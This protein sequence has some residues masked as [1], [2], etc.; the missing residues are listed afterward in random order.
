MPQG[1]IVLVDKTDGWTS[2]DVVAKSRR[3]LGTRKVGHAGTLD[4][5][6][7]GLLLLGAGPATRLLT[8]LVGL[9]K[10][11]VATIRL[12]ASTVTD[13][14]EGEITETAQV[15]DVARVFAS[16]DLIASGVA[17][18]TGAIEQSPSA[19]SA[20]K[21][22]G[23]RA[24][25]RVRAGEQVELKKRP[26]TIHSFEISNVR[27][28][29][30]GQVIDIDAVIRCSSGTY[31]RALARDLGT[32][33]GIGGHLTALRRTA[34]GP[35]S[36]EAATPHAQLVGD[37]TTPG[38]PGTLHAP[39][40]IAR[41]LFPVLTLTVDEAHDLANGKRLDVDPKRQDKAPLVAAILPAEG[42]AAD[43]LVGLVEVRGGRSRVVTNFPAPE[44]TDG[45][46]KKGEA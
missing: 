31:I 27:L 18:L 7:T 9:D 15:D 16:P 20:I 1:A 24:Y 43:R 8:H 4:P 21:V 13:D 32:D 26:V 28:A 41:L 22:D 14:R 39:A 38:D 12:G 11:Y 3:A 10:T 29:D 23:K 42:D 37:E 34:V 19:V 36:V 33:L 6:A 25:D 2:H 35:F 45:S 5:M 30:D 44:R 17:K 46:D 40:D